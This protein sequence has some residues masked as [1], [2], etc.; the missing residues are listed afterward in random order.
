MWSKNFN[1]SAYEKSD[2]KIRNFGTA[3]LLPKTVACNLLTT[4]AVHCKSS[5]Q[6]AYIVVSLKTD[7]R[8]VRPKIRGSTERA[9]RSPFSRPANFRAGET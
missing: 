9:K 2:I 5:A 7:L 3:R 4:S 8:F 1:H 6:L